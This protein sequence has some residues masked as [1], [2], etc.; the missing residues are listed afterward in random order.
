MYSQR[1]E[2]K[3]QENLKRAQEKSFISF[4]FYQYNLCVSLTFLS[5]NASERKTEKTTFV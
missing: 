2:A 1:E 5:L 3:N 4:C